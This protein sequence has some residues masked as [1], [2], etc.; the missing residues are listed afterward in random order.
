ML[1]GFRT[2]PRS[3]AIDRAVVPKE[4][5]RNFAQVAFHHGLVQ[6]LRFLPLAKGE[7][8]FGDEE[9]VQTSVRVSDTRSRRAASSELRA[10]GAD[11]P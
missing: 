4:Q 10:N 2:S 7:K 5:Q 3:S 8:R 1:A 9:S 6:S 11:L